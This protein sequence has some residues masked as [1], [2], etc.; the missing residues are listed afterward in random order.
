VSVRARACVFAA[1]ARVSE[2]ESSFVSRIIIIFTP[3][4]FF[5]KKDVGGG[6]KVR[7]F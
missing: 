6:E 5:Q 4:R 2:G 7:A 1:A 3:T